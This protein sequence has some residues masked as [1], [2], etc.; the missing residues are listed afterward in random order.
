MPAIG[1]LLAGRYRIDARLGAGGMATVWRARDLRLERDVAV[2]VLLP[3]L[4]GDPA[5]TARFDREARALAAIS[6][7]H[8][9]AIFDVVEGSQGSEP[10]LVMELCPDGSLGDRLADGASIAP[11]FARPILANAA[12]GLAALHARGM[13]HRDVTPRNVLLV[14]GSAKLGDFGL[15]RPE[16]ASTTPGGGLTATGAAVGTLGYLAPEIL[17]GRTATPASDVYGLGAVAFRALT[18]AL[19][20]PAGSIAEL[21][22]AGSRVVAPIG[23][24]VPGLAAAA[25][26]AIDRALDAE[27]ARRPTAAELALAFRPTGSTPADERTTLDAWRMAATAAAPGSARPPAA[28]SPP[29]SPERTSF[30]VQPGASQPPHLRPE[31]PAPPPPSRPDAIPQSSSPG[32]R[33]RGQRPLPEAGPDYHGPGF[34][35]GELIAITTT[36]IAII[37]L[38]ILLGGWLD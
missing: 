28:P 8:V 34:W 11:A 17:D 15:A 32:K 1:D 25:A 21:V 24:L 14:G 3:N 27:P 4:A 37:A 31:P 10:F 33:R 7:A 36:L 19:P 30:D 2:K 38:V 20:R 16:D 12:T 29:S 22:A 23:T 35:S 13:V 26:T 6:D 9:V 18:G 5:L